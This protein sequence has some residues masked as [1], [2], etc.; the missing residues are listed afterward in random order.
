MVRTARWL[1]G[2]GG[3]SMEGVLEETTGQSGVGGGTSGTS[4]LRLGRV[5]DDMEEGEVQALA[6][7]TVFVLASICLVEVLLMFLCLVKS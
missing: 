2:G 4:M 6:I 5:A 1:H 7:C 3:G